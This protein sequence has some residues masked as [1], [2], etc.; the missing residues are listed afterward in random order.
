VVVLVSVAGQDAVDAGADHLQEGVL[1]QVGVSGIIERFGK[2]SG[3]ADAVAGLA[4]GSSP[5]SLVS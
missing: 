5:A 3:Q 2:R 4:D 1:G